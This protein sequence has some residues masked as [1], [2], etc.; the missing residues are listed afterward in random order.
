MLRRAPANARRPAAR[1]GWRAACTRRSSSVAA[2][3]GI[4]RCGCALRRTHDMQ[5]RKAKPGGGG[6]VCRAAADVRQ[7]RST[8]PA[9][10]HTPSLRARVRPGGAP[11]PRVA[12]SAARMDFRV[13]PFPFPYPGAH[14]VQVVQPGSGAPAAPQAADTGAGGPHWEPHTVAWDPTAMVAWPAGEAAPA[15]AAEPA[16]GAPPAAAARPSAA[17]CQVPGCDSDAASMREYNQRCRCVACWQVFYVTPAEQQPPFAGCARLTCAPRCGHRVPRS[18]QR[19][20]ERL[21]ARGGA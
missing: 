7:F 3:R 10:R 14:L 20:R 21:P 18:L 17:C 1:R 15:A 2:A 19:S 6:C 9:A 12:A 16:S 11:R 5:A 13:A 4:C 8:K